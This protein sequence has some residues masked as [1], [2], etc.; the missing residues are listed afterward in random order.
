MDEQR[1]IPVDLLP[2]ADEEAAKRVHHLDA[3]LYVSARSYTHKMD[4][5]RLY[6]DEKDQP[7]HFRTF[8]SHRRDALHSRSLLCFRVLETLAAVRRGDVDTSDQD[9]QRRRQAEEVV[10]AAS[11]AVVVGL[12]DGDNTSVDRSAEDMKGCAT[13]PSSVASER[14][15]LR[16]LEG[17]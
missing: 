17:L 16:A 5:H 9:I 6:P 4:L 1:T 7:L 15:A 13:W 8:R 2:I 11:L 10:V 3:Y 14:A 12:K